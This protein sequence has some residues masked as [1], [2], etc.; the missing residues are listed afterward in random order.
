MLM[1]RI[2]L[3][4]GAL[5]AF[6]GVVAGAFGAH[7]LKTVLS[8]D[9]LAVFETAVRYQMYHAFAL[10]IVGW[11]CEQY[12]QASFM[13]AGFLFTGGIVLFS[14][15]LYALAF[16]GTTWLGA[17]TP[18]AGSDEQQT[19][20]LIADLKL[21]TQKHR[22][23]QDDNLGQTRTS[24]LGRLG[25]V[26][27]R[28]D[29]Q[30]FVFLMVLMVVH[31]PVPGPAETGEPLLFIEPIP[32]ATESGPFAPRPLLCLRFRPDGERGEV[33]REHGSQAGLEISG[34]E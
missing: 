17:L 9:M 1:T 20:L 16:T 25:C 34:G 29:H 4:L 15:S 33:R 6:L 7:F 3:A 27:R 28:E 31:R 22:I 13:P 14:G 19:V 8:P 30:H 18:L 32:P 10:L 2:F 26:R 21:P 5:F 23:P 11:A 24:R 12:P